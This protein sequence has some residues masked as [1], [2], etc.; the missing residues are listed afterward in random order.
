MY[1][2]CRRLW[3]VALLLALLLAGCHLVFPFGVTPLAGQDGGADLTL[4]GQP[5]DGSLPDKAS[6][7]Q[8]S[9]DKASLDKKLPPDKAPTADKL[10]PDKGGPTMQWEAMTIPAGVSGPLYDIWGS[11]ASDV[12]AV[13]ANSVVL[14]FG[15]SGKAW[16]KLPHKYS[17]L[18]TN[19]RAVTRGNGAAYIAGDGNTVLSCTSAVCDSSYFKSTEVSMSQID[20]RDIT[21]QGNGNLPCFLVG[22]KGTSGGVLYRVEGA[23]KW[24]EQCSARTASSARHGVALMSG[25]V[26]TVGALGKIVTFSSGGCSAPPSGVGATLEDVTVVGGHVYAVGQLDPAGLKQ[27]VMIHAAS[28]TASFVSIGTGVAVPFYGVWGASATD[29]F[30][31][32]GKGTVLRATGS[33]VKPKQIPGA[34]AQ[35]L[36]AVWGAGAKDLF[37]TT[38]QGQIYRYHLVP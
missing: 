12:Y 7:D 34:S 15:G 20:W 16:T 21:C 6:L 13:G 33:L 28:Q 5:P 1:P 37:V 17:T 9:L 32:G 24:S 35:T 8:A 18:P 14:H 25:K 29:V 19:L 3:P 26:F 30:A 2:G 36:L 31:V 38:D 27:G 23:T 10:L 11:S 22:V 4:D